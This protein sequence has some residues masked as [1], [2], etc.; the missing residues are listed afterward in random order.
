[1]AGCGHAAEAK[2]G[3]VRQDRGEQCVL[4]ITALASAEVGEGGNAG[5]INARYGHDPGLG[6]YTHVSDQHG[7]YSARVMS[8]TSH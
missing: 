6:F 2:V 4:V 3:G 7:P 5:E 1:V 8:A